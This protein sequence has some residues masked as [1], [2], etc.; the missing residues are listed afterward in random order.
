MLPGILYSSL[1]STRLDSL[2]IEGGGS[3]T[4]LGLP[5]VEVMFG[6]G[7][8]VLASTMPKFGVTTL[9]EASSKISLAR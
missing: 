8:A 7:S 2:Q 5:E 6:F 9:G 4:I 1:S 3:E